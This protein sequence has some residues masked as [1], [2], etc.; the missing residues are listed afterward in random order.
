M[1]RKMGMMR[2][3]NLLLEGVAEVGGRFAITLT[4]A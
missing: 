1:T 3:K 4:S 2:R